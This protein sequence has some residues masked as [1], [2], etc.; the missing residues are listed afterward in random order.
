[1]KVKLEVTER[2]FLLIYKTPTACVSS[3]HFPSVCVRVRLC[4]CVC[5][6]VCVR[7]SA[8]CLCVGFVCKV[9]VYQVCV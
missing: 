3:S 1:M 6:C 9:C 5:V 2:F 7:V 4:V 8:M